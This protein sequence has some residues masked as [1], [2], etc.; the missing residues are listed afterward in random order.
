MDEVYISRKLIRFLFE[1][2][3]DSVGERMAIH[4]KL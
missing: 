4:V 1:N 2:F 3:G